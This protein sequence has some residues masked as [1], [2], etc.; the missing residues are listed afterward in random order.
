MKRKTV[1]PWL[2]F[3]M[4]F[5]IAG[6]AVS[7]A[8]QQGRWAV[9]ERTRSVKDDKGDKRSGKDDAIFRIK[10]GNQCMEIDA[11][12]GGRIT[13]FL[14][15]GRNFLTDDKVDSLNWGSTFWPSPQSDWDWP[16]PAAIDNEPY[17]AT[18]EGPG[19]KLVSKKSPAGLVVTK[20]ISGDLQENSFLLNYT[21]TNESG[22]TLKV[23]P[24]EITRVKTGGIAFFPMGAGERRGGLLPLTREKDG[25]VWFVYQE[26]GLPSK[27][28]RQLYS[29]GSEGWLA[30]LNGRTI[31]VK[32]FPDIPLE[33]AAPKEG[34]VELYASPLVK[35]GAESGSAGK[36]SDLLKKDD[37]LRGYV[38]IEH[39]GP[40]Q[41]LEPGA[42]SNWQVIWR[43]RQL[44]D[45]IKAEAGNPELVDFVR[46]LVKKS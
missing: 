9:P 25:I 7:T 46:K 40:F 28:D 21:I 15:D 43:V 5:L 34:E 42:S 24:W 44:P 45:S 11:H 35:D 3:T 2:L 27:G 4:T 30:E 38:E 22:K 41:E 12:L 8:Q 36:T 10:V 6:S 37:R 19:L 39:Q 13:S 29:D 26:E 18:L 17:T 32:Q 20:R 16:P 14:V 31:L 33:A 1:F 23:A